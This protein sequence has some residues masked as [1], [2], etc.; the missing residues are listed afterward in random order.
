M[1]YELF[2]NKKG[3]PLFYPCIAA[4]NFCTSTRI[5]QGVIGNTSSAINNILTVHVNK[6]AYVS[7]APFSHV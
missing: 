5:G 1:L 7:V 6:G 4:I 2:S 3:L